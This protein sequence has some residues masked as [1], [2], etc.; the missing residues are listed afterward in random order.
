LNEQSAA[1]VAAF[2]ALS[3]V[4]V[5]HYVIAAERAAV[6][7]RLF[8]ERVDES[9]VRGVIAGAVAEGVGEG[10]LLDA[11]SRSRPSRP[12]IARMTGAAAN[13]STS[14]TSS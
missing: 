7:S 3:G 11:A 10:W 8:G 1:A 14:F 6:A 4:A 2:L 9:R 12:T 13:R 5:A